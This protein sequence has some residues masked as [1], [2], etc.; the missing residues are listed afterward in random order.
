MYWRDFLYYQRSEQLA[1][2]VLLALIFLV[3]VLNL[4]FANQRRTTVVINQNDSLIAAFDR[5]YNSLEV[6]DNNVSNSVYIHAPSAPNKEKQQESDNNSYTRYKPQKLSMGEKIF[7]NNS[8]TTDW[9][10]VPGI[11]SSYASR[12]VKYRAL[13]GGYVSIEQLR[14]VYGMDDERYESI[15]S[16]ID[17]DELVTKLSVNKLEFKELL[18]HPYLNYK[19]VQAIVNL[20]KKKG[21][22]KSMN[23]LYILNEFTDDDIARIEPYLEF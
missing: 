2:I 18:K 12:I 1:I 21:D 9:K 4:V 22:I 10:K 13:L 16:Y 20:R 14:E 15:I 5:F 3:F 17:V 11:G 23:E 6:T 7:I 8:D 19:Q